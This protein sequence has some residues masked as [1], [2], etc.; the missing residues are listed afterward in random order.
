[1]RN[2]SS[3]AAFAAMMSLAAASLAQAEAGPPASLA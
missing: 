2:L 3:V 1:M